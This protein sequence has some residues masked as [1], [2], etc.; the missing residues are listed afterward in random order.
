MTSARESATL[1]AAEVSSR[2]LDGFALI[3]IDGTGGSGKT[4]LA[5]ELAAVLRGPDGA[6]TVT[7]VHVDDFYREMHGGERLRL[8]PAEGYELY[9]DW[10]RLRE[11]VLAP[12]TSGAS[13]AYRRYDWPSGRIVPGEL[14]RVPHAGIVIVEGVQSVRPELE[15]YYD[16]TVLVDTPFDV[17]LTRMVTRGREQG[18]GD[19]EQRWQAADRYYFATTEPWTRVDLIVKGL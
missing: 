11:E 14:H 6:T 15:G 5:E 10:E 1:I 4:T 3:G 9:Y 12:L 17:S 16:L 8:T 18:P 13:A 7:I 19:W 2:T